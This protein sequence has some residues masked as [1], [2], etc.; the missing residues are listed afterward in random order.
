MGVRLKLMS[1]DICI[2]ITEF[3]QCIF[4][5]LFIHFTR[6]IKVLAFVDL[7]TKNYVLSSLSKVRASYFLINVCKRVKNTKLEPC[8]LIKSKNI[9]EEGS[10]L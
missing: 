5:F 8:F 10:L 2:Q 9:S 7:R 3:C 6:F 1:V 4:V